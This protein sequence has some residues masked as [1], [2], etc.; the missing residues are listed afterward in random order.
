M[1]PSTYL[2]MIAGGVP[3]HG[4]GA[5]DDSLRILAQEALGSAQIHYIRS[6]HPVEGRYHYIA[7]P[8]AALSSEPTPITAI[9]MALPGH[10]AHQG[11]GAY[12]LEVGTYKVVALFDGVQL[13][14]AC[15][16]SDLIQ[17]LLAEQAL[18]VILVPP[19]TVAWRFQSN[20]TQMNDLADRLTSKVTRFSLWL[21]AGAMLLYGGLLTADG[22]LAARIA[23]NAGATEQALASALTSVQIGSPLAKQ[24]AEYQQ[25][26]ALA[27]RAGGW[28]DAYEA[29]GTVE[30][31]RIFVPSWITPDYISTLGAGVTA[32]RDTADE[33]LLVLLKGSPAGGKHLSS[34]ETV[35]KPADQPSMRPAATRPGTGTPPR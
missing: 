9:A 25:R 29:K 30:S 13:D 15:N 8:S 26:G 21:L 6:T 2:T 10:P 11:P 4:Q 31:F 33:Q 12:V 24:I 7:L 22:W 32:D 16:E 5:V 35:A 14:I 34:S 1:Q 18:P 3:E 28:I 27:V 20:F 19:E 23:T 17:D